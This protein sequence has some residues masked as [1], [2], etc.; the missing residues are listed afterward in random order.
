M[1]P[2]K[3]LEQFLINNPDCRKYTI[4]YVRNF[5][6]EHTEKDFCCPVCDRKVFT[7]KR[8]IND[9]MA[10]SL[11]RLYRYSIER[12][13]D[14]LTTFVHVSNFGV[15]R[16]RAG[17]GDFAK[18][19]FWGLVSEEPPVNSKLKPRSGYWRMT[20][21]GVSFAL[22]KTEV[23]K[24]V[25]VRLNKPILFSQATISIQQCL[26]EPFQYQEIIGR[27]FQSQG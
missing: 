18:L 25:H 8:S 26:N 23:S 5:I 15:L 13:D 24:N 21:S 19:R 9:V 4:P 10:I 17:G 20:E 27:S 16:G 14:P 12:G 22:K 6:K 2:K 3:K 11:I 1:T 7:Y